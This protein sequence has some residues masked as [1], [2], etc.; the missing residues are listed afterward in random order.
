MNKPQA[1]YLIVT[2]LVIAAALFLYKANSS[3][4][5]LRSTWSSGAIA[6]RPGVVMLGEQAASIGI[7][8]RS[9]NYFNAIWPALVFGI[10]IG[11]AVRAFVSP[12]RLARL[13]LNRPVKAQLAAG[14]AGAPLMLC[15]CCVAPVFM[16][17]AEISGRL[18]PALG[19]LLASP[20]LNPAALALTFMLF[21]PPIAAARAV[22]ALIVVLVVGPAIERMFQ[23]VNFEKP[24]SVEE[25][26]PATF[27]KS[28][29]VVSMR[30]VPALI[31]GVIVSMF[32]I[33]SLSSTL[34]ISPE[35]RTA[36]ILI[37][38]TLAVPLALPTFLEIPLAL[39]LLAAGL[40][41]GAAVALLFAGP[42]VSLPSLLS[43]ARV[44]GWKIAAMVAALVWV[45]AA[46]G[47][48]LIG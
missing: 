37:T 43:V 34:F 12:D 28:I 24:E 14:L 8:E 4:V 33:E 32:L 3:I 18:G 47:G 45:L 5:V 2:P 21:E 6:A 26:T 15:S 16:S 40:P 35:A 11:A 9:L 10:L 41:A 1:G 19:L 38:A 22:L 42:A 48:L 44:G 17:V 27:L 36:A 23:H 31:I 39:S 13:A 46:G 7:L 30:T 25:S 29:F 20:V